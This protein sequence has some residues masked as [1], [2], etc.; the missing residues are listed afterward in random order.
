MTGSS[1]RRM[2]MRALPPL[3]SLARRSALATGI[4]ALLGVGQADAQGA[5]KFGVQLSALSTSIGVGSSSTGGVGL[6][7]QFRFNRLYRSASSGVVSLGIGG[8]WTTHSSGPDDITITG[9]FVEPRWVPALPYERFFPY[10]AGRVALLNQSNNFGTSSSGFAFG[11]GGGIA[12]VLTA[13]VNIDAGVA[14]IRQSFGDFTFTRAGLSGPGGF[15]PFT[16]Y[17]AK[18]GFSVGLP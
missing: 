4:V 5:Q 18:I 16:T 9:A 12:Y 13:N 11:A 14:I 10:L 8:Q 6:E 1:L 7:P 15:D 17:A 3:L 2:S